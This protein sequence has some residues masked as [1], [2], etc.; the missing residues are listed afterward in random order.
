VS[1]SQELCSHLLLPMRAPALVEITPMLDPCRVTLMEPLLAALA[2][3]TE[4][5]VAHDA[6]IPRVKL[7]VRRPAVMMARL[8][9]VT[10]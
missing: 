6:E 1:D 8:L 3:R 7:P 5:P 10:P 9:P 4:L 2:R